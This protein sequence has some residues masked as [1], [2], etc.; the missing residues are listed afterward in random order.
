MELESTTDQHRS[1]CNAVMEPVLASNPQNVLVSC[2]GDYQCRHHEQPD[3]NQ[4]RVILASVGR[5]SNWTNKPSGINQYFAQ[6]PIGCRERP[7]DRLDHCQTQCK[8]TAKTLRT[9]LPLRI[10][11]GKTNARQSDKSCQI[12]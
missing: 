8:R 2:W 4:H 3:A 6:F 11:K 1:N 7:R 9:H 10:G 5:K 12:G